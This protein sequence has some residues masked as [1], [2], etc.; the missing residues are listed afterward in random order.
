MTPALEERL[1][2]I[3]EQI[4]KLPTVLIDG[5]PAVVLFLSFTDGTARAQTLTISGSDGAS[6]WQSALPHLMQASDRLDWLRIDWV[7]AVER[8]DWDGLRQRLAATKRNYFRLGIALDAKLERAFLETEINANAMLYGGKGYP[9]ATVNEAN[10]RRY[11]RLRHGI[12]AID[13]SDDRPIWL[14]STAGL[15]MDGDGV[16]HAIRQQGRNAGRR[17]IDRLDPD[18]LQTLIDDGSRY[19]ASQVQADGRFHYG[20]HPCFDRPIS[21]YNSLR[22]ASSC[23]A[24]LESW[25]V[26]RDPGVLAAIERALAYLEQEL[27]RP[28]L[29]P[30]GTQA[31]FLIDPGNEIKLGGNAVCLLALVKYSELLATDRYRDLL[32]RLAVGILHMQD[33]ASGGFVHVLDYP[34][35]AVKQAFRIIYY[36]GEAAFGLMRLYGLTGDP[37]WIDAVARAFDHFIAAGHASAHDHWLGYCANELTRHRPAEDWFR[38]GLDNVRD[39]LD[40]VEHRIT[41]FPTLLELMMAAQQ[42]IARLATDPDHRPLLDSIDLARF[43]RAL[44]ARAHYLLNGHFWPELAM[45]FANPARIVG[46]FFIRHHAFRVRID[47]VEHYL[48]G[49]IAYR[50]HLIEQQAEAE[51]LPDEQ[52]WTPRSVMQ[53]TGGRW[54]IPPSADWRAQG[55]CIH[56]PSQQPGDMVVMRGREGERGIAPPLF[57]R[58]K[59]MAAAVI[60]SAPDRYIDSGLPVLAVP[61]CDAAMLA[62]GRHARERSAGKL[63]GVTGSA[64]KTTMVAMLA[65]ALR[66]WGRVGETRMNANLPHGIAWNLASIPWDTPHVVMEMAIGRMKQ[67]AQLTRP[68]IAVFTNIAAAHLEFHRDLA[69]VARRKSAIFEGMTPGGTAILNADMAELPLVRALAQAHDLHVV[70]YGEGAD[71]DFRLLDRQDVQLTVQTPAGRIDYPLQAPGRHMAL[72]S[73]AVLATLSTL[74]LD[75]GRGVAALADFRPLAGRGEELRLTIGGRHIR[76]IDEAYNANPASMGA[77]L[78]LLGTQI[79][80]RRIA[81]LGEMLELGP[82]AAD[83]HGALAPLIADQGIDRVHVMG[84]FYTAF[85]AT[86][87]MACR[88]LYADHVDQLFDHVMAGVQDGDILL[89][90][91]SHGSGLHA[92]VARLKAQARLEEQLGREVIAAA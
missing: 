91:G 53:A 39:Y 90:K 49:L 28:A 75:A 32:E 85:W 37:R 68:D 67:N 24:M 57:P 52:G 16:V 80:G 73:V 42:M 48:S 34:S 17:T 38:F 31:A 22:H 26:T 19:L 20:W 72:N 81:L 82:D 11:A 84:G 41:T 65:R 56:P 70:T 83:Y 7:R 21:A 14:F 18:L 25:E 92:L 33:A 46:S 88:G 69:T 44:H 59:P 30:D 2:V 13:F 77:A 9:T 23:Y 74:S 45:F 76:L 60:T 29:L 62:L 12:R 54:V 61:D 66:P 47:D 58:L 27:I 1:A 63:I 50:R 15:F 55:L 43:D 3:G 5:S 35:L 4:G 10:F 89:I 86:L 71:A 51:A 6:C 78:E 8:T 79:G 64:G 40:F 87:P 36:D